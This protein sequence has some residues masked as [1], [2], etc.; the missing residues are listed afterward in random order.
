M[1]ELIGRISAS[2]GIEP[3]V[4]RNAIG[5]ILGFLRKEGPQ[6]EIDELFAT[7]PG[8]ADAAAASDAG[9]GDGAGPSE[10]MGLAG[11][12]SNLGLGMGQMQT[13]GRQV[14]AYAREAAGDERIGQVV[15][16]IPGLSQFL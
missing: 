11:K 7:V 3:E 10:L 6:A 13:I 4:A 14:F 15:G 12:L 5:L 2:A 9:G 16:A 1:E 8:A